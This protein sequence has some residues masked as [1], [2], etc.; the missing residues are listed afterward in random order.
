[1]LLSIGLGLVIGFIYKHTNRGMNCEASFLSTL[2]LLA[3]DC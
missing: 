3:P 2:V 1:M